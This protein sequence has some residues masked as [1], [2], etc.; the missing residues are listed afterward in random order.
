M[1]RDS[2]FIGG[3]P[4][5]ANYFAILEEIRRNAFVD[6]GWVFQLKGISDAS[7]HKGFGFIHCFSEQASQS[8]FNLKRFTIQGR[9]VECKPSWTLQ[10]H[11]HLTDEA[12]QRKV[13]ISGI[14]KATTKQ[15]VHSYFS[16]F[17]QVSCICLGKDKKTGRRLGFCIVEFASSSDTSKVLAFAQH[18]IDGKPVECSKLLLRHELLKANPTNYNWTSEY[19]CPDGLPRRSN[20]MT[21]AGRIC[22]PHQPWSPCCMANPQV[23]EHS[24]CFRQPGSCSSTYLPKGQENSKRRTKHPPSAGFCQISTPPPSDHYCIA[25]NQPTRIC[26]FNPNAIPDPQQSKPDLINNRLSQQAAGQFSSSPRRADSKPHSPICEISKSEVIKRPHDRV[27]RCLP[28]GQTQQHQSLPHCST[29][30]G[31]IASIKVTKSHYTL[32][33]SKSGILSSLAISLS[34]EKKGEQASPELEDDYW[35]IKYARRSYSTCLD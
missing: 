8:F 29:T 15:T 25:Q 18:F 4:P 21:A 26:S 16:C 32:K 30:G 13:F 20:P 24:T 1:P 3:I 2:Y 19:D 11:R 23:P 27:M 34:D 7:L 12:R 14:R 6:K 22:P 28:V 5:Q 10:E 9:E 33:K 35:N 31:P 17:G